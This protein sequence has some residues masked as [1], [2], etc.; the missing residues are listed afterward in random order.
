MPV[1]GTDEE[2]LDV[3][4]DLPVWETWKTVEDAVTWSMSQGVF[5]AGVHA[6]NSFNKLAKELATQPIMGTTILYKAWYE[7]VMSKK[8]GSKV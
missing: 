6:A 8:E 2:A 1:E 4:G 3:L 7:K 5:N